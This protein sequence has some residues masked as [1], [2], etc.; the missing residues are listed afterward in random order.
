MEARSTVRVG[1]LTLSLLALGLLAACGGGG[2]EPAAPTFEQTLVD[3]SP[4]QGSTAGG[5]RVTLTGSGFTHELLEIRSVFFGSEPALEVVVESD[6]TITCTAPAGT[7]GTVVV[8]LFGGSLQDPLL[9]AGYRYVASTLFVADGPAAATPNLYRVDLD[10]GTWGLIGPIGYAVRGLA[11]AG[12]DRLYGVEAGLPNRLIEI[13]AVTGRGTPVALLRDILT[14]AA[15]E[16]LDL[17]FVDGRLLA[18]TLAGTLALIDPTSGEVKTLDQLDGPA[19]GPGL[20]A[21]ESG[22]IYLAPEAADNELLAWDPVT[23]VQPAGVTLDPLGPG[24]LDAL[25]V[26]GGQ[27]YGVELP[28]AGDKGVNLVRIDPETGLLWPVM[29]LPPHVESVAGEF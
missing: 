2:A 16:V 20:A 1:G 28:P 4:L 14:G 26:Q 13:D 12:P 9:S 11:L 21:T 19:T 29:D 23:G 25:T 17:T 7:L 22:Q 18:R 6:R 3:V 10:A 8:N 24:A 5:T 15:V 27:L